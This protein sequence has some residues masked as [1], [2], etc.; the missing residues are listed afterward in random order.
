MSGKYS[1]TSF[2]LRVL[3]AITQL[4]P[5]GILAEVAGKRGRAAMKRLAAL[6]LTQTGPAFG[7]EVVTATR[8]GCDVS[9]VPD[10]L[11]PMMPFDVRI[12]GIVAHAAPRGVVLSGLSDAAQ[13][14]VWLLRHRG[15][16][17]VRNVRGDVCV[18]TAEAG[19]DAAERR[20]GE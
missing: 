12:F 4:G 15:L 18:F 11:A 13:E 3:S 14:S 9:N 6:G 20:E 2:E 8:E 7:V 19:A 10:L 16:V 1:L 17:T 5:T